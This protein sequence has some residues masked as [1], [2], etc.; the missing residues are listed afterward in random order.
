MY[1]KT[2]NNQQLQI[3]NDCNA[4]GLDSSKFAKPHIDEFKMILAFQALRNNDDLSLFLDD[5]NHEQL[6]EI[7]LG[8]KSKIN[9]TK[10]LDPSLHAD[11]M[12]MLRLKLESEL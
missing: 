11:H 6:D 12:H 2:F 9:I 10:Y 4:L 3:I 5:Y 1:T 7:R 8:L